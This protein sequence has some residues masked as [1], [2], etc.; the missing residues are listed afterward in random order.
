MSLEHELIDFRISLGLSRPFFYRLLVD[1]SIS[2]AFQ[3]D[4]EKL[5][6]D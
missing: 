5:F 3:T 2:S 6:V 4:E 1:Q